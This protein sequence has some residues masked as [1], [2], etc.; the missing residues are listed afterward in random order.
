ML[1]TKL[2]SKTLLLI[3]ALG[4]IPYIVITFWLKDLPSIFPK[5]DKLAELIAGFS[6][7][8]S[9]A[10]PFWWTIEFFTS[11]A[12]QVD[13]AKKQRVFLDNARQYFNTMV[14]VI[15]PD[16]QGDCLSVARFSHVSQAASQENKANEEYALLLFEMVDHHYMHLTRDRDAIAPYK[17][18]YSVE[19][20]RALNFL[21]DSFNYTL[22]FGKKS[23]TDRLFESAMSALQAFGGNLIKLENAYRKE[24]NLPPFVSLFDT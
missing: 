8:F 17:E 24:H 5:A 3:W 7:A 1:P 23:S 9:S 12:R 2:S 6:S 22:T 19:F 15:V 18:D 4:T 11:R 14:R 16:I 13:R 20:N 10:F 21:D